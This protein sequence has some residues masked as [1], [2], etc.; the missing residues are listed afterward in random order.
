MPPPGCWLIRRRCRNRAP[1][2]HEK[3]NQQRNELHFL[4]R[5]RRRLHLIWRRTAEARTSAW[6]M[7]ARMHYS[8][9]ERSSLGGFPNGKPNRSVFL[10]RVQRHGAFRAG[11][12]HRPAVRGSRGILAFD[13]NRV[14]GNALIRLVLPCQR[15]IARVSPPHWGRGNGGP[16]A[17]IRAIGDGIPLSV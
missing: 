3:K 14:L 13:S 9:S 11:L 17:R 16:S 1:R 5:V 7:R 8:T 4:P 15:H 10:C 6:W 2:E 12:P